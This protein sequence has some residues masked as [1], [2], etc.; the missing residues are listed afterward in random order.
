MFRGRCSVSAHGYI[1]DQIEHEINI[2]NAARQSGVKRIVKLSAPVIQPSAIVKVSEWH[3]T[4]DN[5]LIKTQMNSA[6]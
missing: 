2:I 1:S 3:N 6:A 4:I 5:Y